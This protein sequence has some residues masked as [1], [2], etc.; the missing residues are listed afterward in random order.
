[1][2]VLDEYRIR[3]QARSGMEVGMENTETEYGI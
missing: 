3:N 2:T 1:L